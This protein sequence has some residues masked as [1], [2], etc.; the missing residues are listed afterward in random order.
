MDTLQAMSGKADWVWVD[1][2]TRLPMD[3]GI[4]HEMKRLGYKICLVSPELQGQPE[5]MAA[6]AEQ[7]KNERIVFDAICTKEYN[8]S[9][10]R[11]ML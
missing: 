5:K 11:G 6:Y 10:W 3:H 9:R 2:F 4:Y 8:I 1:T 7:I